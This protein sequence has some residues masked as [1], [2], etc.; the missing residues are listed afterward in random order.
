VKGRG[1]SPPSF[2][3][4]QISFAS[5]IKGWM[6]DI[7]QRLGLKF[8]Y[9]DIEVKD[10]EKKR[11]DVILWEKR[12]EKPALLI[13][14]WDAK[15]DPWGQA[16]DSAISKAWKNN[17][18]YFAVWNLTHFYC[19]DTFAQG[20]IIDRLWWPH[21]GV[22]EVVCEAHTY[23]D[24][25]LRYSDSIKKYLENF[26]SEFEQ[27]YYGF[28]AKPL[29]GID[30]RFIYWLR[31]AINALSIPILENIKMIANEDAD[32]RKN[33]VK[34]FKEQGWSFRG[35]DED[36]EKVARQ[37][38]YLLM[39]KILFY[40]V[41]RS[42]PRYRRHLPKITIPVVGLTGS[43]LKERLD[44]YF[45]KA[46]EI[47]GNYETIL[48]TDFLDSITPS[49]EAANLLVD[50]INRFGE[51]D[52]SEIVKGNYEILGNIFQK[53]IPEGER[54]KL[55]QYYTRS[56]VVDLIVGFCVRSSE[57]RVLDG[58]C[59]AGTFLVRSYVRKKLMDPR[60]THREL[61]KDLYGVDI[62]KFPAHLTIINLASKDLSEI[63][64]YPNILHKDFFD[65]NPGGQYTLAEIRVETL[66]GEKK[67]IGIPTFFDAVVMNPPYTRQ[68][69]M[70][71]VLEEEKDK[72]Y[73]RCIEDWKTMSR[74]PA[75]K[76]PKLSKR[77]SI[78]VYFFIH[79]GSFLK[80]G[81]RLGLI[82]SNSWLDVDY[83]GDLQ[84]FF[85][86]NFKIKAVIESKVER[87]FEDADINTAITILERCSNSEERDRNVVRFVQ[88]KKPLKEFIPPVEDEKE[89]W[90]YVESLIQL[91]ESKDGYYE[92]EKIRMFT[93]I[94]KELWDEGYDDEAREY[95][96]SKWGKYVRAPDIFFKILE[97]GKG[98]LV[99]LKEVAEVRRGFTTGANEFFYLTEEETQKWGIERE[100]WMHPLKRGEEAPVPEHVWKDRRGEYFKASQYAERMRLED[101]LRDDGYVYWIPNYVIKSPRECRSILIDPK[102]LKYRVLLIHK[103]KSELK[104]TNVLKYIEWGE[105][106]GFHLRP[107]CKSR[108]RWYE[109]GKVD[110]P[111][112]WR[113]TYNESFGV[114][115]N[116]AKVVIDKVMYG[117][118]PAKKDDAKIILAFLNSSLIP[119]FAEMFGT[120]QLGQ[121][122]LFTA[123]YEI[124][125]IPIIDP[126]KIPKDKRQK[127]EDLVEK[128]SNRLI[129]NVFDE[130]GADLS[131]EVSL[132]KV[133]PD[134]RELDKIIMGE[135]LGLTEEEQ[136]EV[137]RAVIDL[138]K[139]R[140][141][142]AKSVQK[143]KK[144]G[145]LDVDELVDSVLRDV[146]RLHGIKA[147][148]FPEDYIGECPHKVV[149]VPKGSK[150]EASFD[151]EGPY[152]QIDKEKIRCASIY[153]AKYI[154]Y[155]ILAGKTRIPIPE[156]ENML[157][158]AVEER[159]RLL[160]QARR[161]VEDFLNEAIA[162]KKLREKVRFK[163]FKRLGI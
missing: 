99:P 1:S 159:E 75:E 21:S 66:S 36:F 58:A 114:F 97:K 29:L 2:K 98:I 68:E 81:G 38:V 109:L 4:T 49:D 88:L 65:V 134:R 130:I 86:E 156:D 30:E 163:A 112:I 82:T 151:L 32:F 89:R 56:D 102:S 34:Y 52:F 77:A 27:I 20:E 105:S 126:Q 60:K 135:I 84:R 148:R 117:I 3:F 158:Q 116:E 100:F 25:I 162:D 15:T 155:A 10:P 41:L 153:E 132:E 96:G 150:V 71:D 53:L 124:A 59:G 45:K 7:I 139:S 87:W 50:F 72:A 138:V 44:N 118:L 95:V 145:E 13:E 11:A 90:A 5:E 51:Y 146:E 46:Y 103:D 119:L 40:N 16:L 48:L 106:Q 12:K 157:K 69:E 154:K 121:G 63:E 152:V 39:N 104:G 128:L 113:S 78:Y 79:G 136:L 131:E 92:D 85:L 64:N 141:E 101:V 8:E 17:I 160:E 31:G 80:E 115:L 108:K 144:V 94:Q 14:I 127:L 73:R 43:T 140:V 111:L 67:T 57:D 23:D 142:R 93:K 149:E 61:I 74:Y 24:A 28:K 55:G 83:G 9:A 125:A 122:A 120:V 47:T 62:A 129:S 123:V 107:T 54:H 18:P 137:Y 161:S 22:V 70:E 143:R 26:L 76:E 33:L 147:R 19:W 91:I 42:I 6:N 110:Y 35:V 133:K 37:Y